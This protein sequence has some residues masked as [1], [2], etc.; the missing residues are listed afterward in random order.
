VDIRIAAAPVSWG[1]LEKDTPGVPPYSLVLDQIAEAGYTG[2]ELGPYGYMPFDVPLLRDELEVRGLSLVSAFVVYSF[3]EGS[4][5]P[6]LHTEALETIGLLAAMGCSHFALS[7]ALFVEGHRANRAGRI[8]PEDSLDASA[9]DRAAEHVGSFARMAWEQF[10]LRTCLHPHVGAYLEAD[11]EIDAL[12]ER[13]DPAFVGLCFDMAHIAYG[14]GDPARVL[15]RWGDRAWHLHAKECDGEVREEVLAR[16]GDYFD[17]VASGVFPALGMGTI[18]WPEID[19]ILR[20]IGY[21]GWATVEQD[22]LPGRGVA[23]LECAVRNRAFLQDELG[24]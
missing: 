17:G 2:T 6:D 9:W 4:G 18:A 21:A 15:R 22:I 8:R 5:R 16:E 24:W 7:D 1:V 10:G 19:S 20:G 3:L 11:F 23:P 12:L 14:G 13:T